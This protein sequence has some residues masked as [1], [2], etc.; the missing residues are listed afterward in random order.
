MK[1]FQEKLEN[2]IE[3][4]NDNN[5]TYYVAHNLNINLLK[6]NCE[7]KNYVYMVYSHG[8][9]PL[10]THPTSITKKRATT[11]DHIYTNNVT[12]KIENFI[13]MHD[14]TDHLPV[15]VCTDFQRFPKNLNKT[16]VL[17]RD[18]NKFQTTSFVEDQLDNLFS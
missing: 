5:D 1:K 12:H 4:L 16:S 3:Y 18:T 7:I 8:C 15:L 14:L 2:T 17:L 9:I 11:I 6:T 10:I 13:I